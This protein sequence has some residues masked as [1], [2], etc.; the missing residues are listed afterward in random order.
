MATTES[1]LILQNMNSKTRPR[2]KRETSCFCRLYLLP[3]T[4]CMPVEGVWREKW[5]IHL[6]LLLR[7]MQHLSKASPMTTLLLGTVSNWKWD[8]PDLKIDSNNKQFYYLGLSDNFKLPK[9]DL[10][11]RT[12]WESIIRFDGEVW[13]TQEKKM[14]HNNEPLGGMP[15]D[16]IQLRWCLDV[17]SAD[18]HAWALQA[19]ALKRIKVQ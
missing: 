10:E 19:H 12:H 13:K 6:T 18:I 14:L 15:A 3:A 11:V 1:L 17:W 8:S 4:F 5:P 9:P 16:L 2:Q 7:W